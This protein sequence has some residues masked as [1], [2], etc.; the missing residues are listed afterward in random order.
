ME[1]E[2]ELIA[3]ESSAPPPVTY[4]AISADA[5]DQPGHMLVRI[6]DIRFQ[7]AE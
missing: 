6:A 1:A 3:C 4:I 2:C 5:D 7:G